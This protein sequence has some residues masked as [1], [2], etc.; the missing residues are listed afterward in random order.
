MRP[1]RPIPAS[2]LK[3]IKQSLKNA[4][5]VQEYRHAHVLYLRGHFGKTIQEIAQITDYSRQRVDT[6]IGDYF[7]QGVDI[8]KAADKPRK[9]K[10]GNMT[11]EEEKAFIF[12]YLEKA[13]NG[14]II[15]TGALQKSYEKII[16]K[17]TSSSVIYNIL[18]RHG[19]RKIAPRPTH[20]NKNS[21]KATAFK[22][23]L[24]N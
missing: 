22:K 16:G 3:T 20:P 14:E 23:T 1:Q 9:R 17:E 11:L 4:K 15:E 18:H 13:K 7:K 19:W 10:W 24:A 21:E 2:D 5:S 12:G 8:L 6:I